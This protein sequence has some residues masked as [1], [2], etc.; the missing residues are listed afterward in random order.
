MSFMSMAVSFLEIADER[1]LHVT[2]NLNSISIGH[3]IWKRQSDRDRAKE[4][5][6][7]AWRL[8][9]PHTIRKWQFTLTSQ[10]KYDFNL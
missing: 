9:I 3:E 7:I 10:T 8:N 5:D 6:A 1:Q 4:S 2:C